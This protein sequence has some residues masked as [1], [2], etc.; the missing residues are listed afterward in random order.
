MTRALEF[1]TSGAGAAWE[2]VYEDLAFTAFALAS[3]ADDGAIARLFT[4]V[5]SVLADWVAIEA[6]R[7][8]LRGA[9]IAARAQVKVADAALDLAL[10][11]IAEAV[12]AETDGSRDH[13]L[14]QRFFPE[15]H[16]RVIALGLDAELP[17]AGLVMAQLDEGDAPTSLTANADG[18]RLCLTVGN[19]ALVA[20]AETYAALGRLQARVEAWF[21]TAF[22]VHENVQADLID[23]G[24]ER[25]LSERWA[26]SFFAG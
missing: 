13:D 7:R 18:L 10:G 20:R 1:G 25:G 26:E 4:Q 16:E 15:P 24:D 23:L 19:Q 12:L 22:A 5:Q 11:K 3:Q 14:Y 21:E 6:D 2:E 9:A 17:S 8:Q